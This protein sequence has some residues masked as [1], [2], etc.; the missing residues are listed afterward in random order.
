MAEHL[1]LTDAASGSHAKIA[2]E[3]GFNCYEFVA[4]LPGKRIDVLAAQPEVLERGE[5]PSWSGIPLL[6]PYPNR[7]RGGRFE[8]DGREYL[9]PKENV[10]YVGENAIHGF[11]LDRAWRVTRQ[12]ASSATGTFRLSQDAPERLDL[13]PADFEI[14]VRYEVLGPALRCDVKITNP[15]TKPLPFGFGTHPY[16]KLPLAGSSR[17][18]ECLIEVPAAKRY[19]L[20]GG[21][22]TGR[23]LPV[24]GD[25][26]LREGAALGGLK[27]DDVYTDVRYEAEGLVTRVVDPRAGLEVVQTADRSFRELVVFTPFWTQAVCI[28]PYTCTT[29]AIHLQQQGL[30]AGLRVLAPGATFE[31]WFTLRV[32]PVVA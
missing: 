11:C 14:E 31:T 27:L 6:F 3:F 25:F 23:T 30:D 12:T 28:E 20:Q 9:L 24:E 22:P 13:W 16:F 19:E 10:A 17:Y 5:K 7:I 29:D 15:D 26:D 4:G 21:L 1:T 2:A 18:E 8:W 32:G